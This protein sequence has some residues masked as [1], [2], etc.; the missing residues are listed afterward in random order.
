M[1]LSIF[2]LLGEFPGLPSDLHG[3]NKMPSSAEGIIQLCLLRSEGSIHS[4]HV[5]PINRF[6]FVS[7]SL[8]AQSW[9]LEHLPALWCM[10]S[11]ENH[12][13][14]VLFPSPPDSSSFPF[15]VFPSLP[16][17]LA[18][19]TTSGHGVWWGLPPHV[20]VLQNAARRILWLW[21]E[22]LVVSLCRLPEQSHSNHC[23]KSCA[24]THAWEGWEAGQDSVGC[25]LLSPHQQ[26]L[27]GRL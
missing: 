16:E 26:L 4:F 13:R 9:C 10:K 25:E 7:N 5:N 17:N 8:S 3:K 6:C 18:V 15:P 24:E 27:T 12:H 11:R 1:S 14:L 23:V 19:N 2:G 20:P 21:L 22:N